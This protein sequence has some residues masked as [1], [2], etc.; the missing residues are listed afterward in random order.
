MVNKKHE[1]QRGIKLIK[2]K[3]QQS[4]VSM[5]PAHHTTRLRSTEKAQELAG[6][7]AQNLD[8]CSETSGRTH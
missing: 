4:F 6:V 8:Q 5:L 7:Q 2:S 3:T 1:S